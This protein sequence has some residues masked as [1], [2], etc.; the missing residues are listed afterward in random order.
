MVS[1]SPFKIAVDDIRTRGQECYVTHVTHDPCPDLQKVGPNRI[2]SI[3]AYRVESNMIIVHKESKIIPMPINCIVKLSF[4]SRL[5][6]VEVQ[7]IYDDFVDLMAKVTSVKDSGLDKVEFMTSEINSGRAVR[8]KAF[9]HDNAEKEAAMTYQGKVIVVRNG[10]M[11]EKFTK[12]AFVS[13]RF[14][15]I[16]LK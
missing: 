12:S 10:K 3:G 7:Y 11:E 15:S 1:D 6:M 16:V 8:V 14:A 13:V 5:K 9:V 4:E 2:Y